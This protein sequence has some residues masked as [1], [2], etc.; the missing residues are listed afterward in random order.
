ML[1]TLIVP[2]LPQ[3]VAITED[4]MMLSVESSFN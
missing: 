2:A 4:Y 1:E 3:P